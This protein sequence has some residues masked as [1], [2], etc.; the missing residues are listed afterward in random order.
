MYLELKKLL[1]V[2]KDKLDEYLVDMLNR[3]LIEYKND[4]LSISEKGI[5]ILIAQNIFDLTDQEDEFI[6]NKINK[7]EAWDIYKPYAPDI[8]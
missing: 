4:L 5:R 3:G 6:N 8:F 2:S 1:G 7:D